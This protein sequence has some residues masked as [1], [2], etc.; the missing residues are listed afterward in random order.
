MAIWQVGTFG[1]VSNI[2][3][4]NAKDRTKLFCAVLYC[5]YCT[6]VRPFF[7]FLS[8]FVSGS[9]GVVVFG[10]FCVLSA[11][12]KKARKKVLAARERKNVCKKSNC[13]SLPAFFQTRPDVG[14]YLEVTNSTAI[15]ARDTP[16]A[17]SDYAAT[18]TCARL[19]VDET[20]SAVKT[21][22]VRNG[23]KRFSETAYSQ[24]RGRSKIC[25]VYPGTFEDNWEHLKTIGNF[26]FIDC[27]P[28]RAKG[29][30]LLFSSADNDKWAPVGQ[31]PNFHELCVPAVRGKVRRL[32]AIRRRV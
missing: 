17:C 2:K 18:S 4:C 23:L 32:G 26:E 6:F 24:L 3:E 20:R 14:A 13:M 19:L 15:A 12:L 21:G 22:P 10:D 25:C 30:A 5:T 11:S 28:K 29:I 1:E 8:E 27:V 16:I 9:I 7:D 31:F